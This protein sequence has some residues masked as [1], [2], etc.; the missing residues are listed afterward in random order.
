M[1]WGRLARSHASQRLAE[2][3]GPISCLWIQRPIDRG[4]SDEPATAV[5]VDSR[6]GRA[7]ITAYGV[8]APG[9]G[10]GGRDASGQ[11]STFDTKTG[12]LL[13]TVAMG[14]YPLE[15][16]VVAYAGPITPAK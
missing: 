9:Y 14:Q 5:A 1:R 8:G 2:A 12:A 3:T 15:L 10:L 4:R 6:P 13:G 16:A 7:F 11:K